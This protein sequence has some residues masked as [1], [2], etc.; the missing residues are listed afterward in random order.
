M[1]MGWTAP[2]IPYLTSEDSHIQMTLQEAEWMESYLLIGVLVAM[3]LTIYA[4]DKIGRKL[5]LLASC[6]ILIISWISIALSARIEYIYTARFF[7]GFGLNMAFVA[8]LMYIGELAHKNFR[9]IISS[10]MF[11]MPLLGKLVVYGIAPSFPFYVSSAIATVLLVIQLVLFSFMPESPHYLISKNKNEEANKSLQKFRGDSDVNQEF[12]EIVKAVDYHRKEKTNTLKAIVSVKSYRKVLLIVFML[13]IVQPFSCHEI[14]LMNLHEI[15]NTAASSYI[16]STM[17]AIIFAALMLVGGLLSSA[18][19]D[20][21]GR[22]FLLIFSSVS[23][24][25]CLIMLA[26]Y[27]HL[28]KNGYS[29]NSVSWIPIALVMV[30]AIVFEI[31]LGLVPIVLIGELFAPKVKALGMSLS[32]G[33]YIIASIISLQVY[34]YFKNAFGTHIP[35]YSFGCWTMISSLIVYFFIPETKG[36]SLEEIQQIFIGEEFETDNRVKLER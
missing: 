10:I 8:S 4:V 34:F 28:G 36:R 7:K 13:D 6:F 25:L 18:T 24:G 33:M 19:I 15:L 23:T 35:F 32:C 14:I 12:E 2:M 22:K 20:K 11:V 9:G 27:F 26:I 3:P 1:A 5:T 30:Y 29:L 16:D 17:T 31:G 21:F